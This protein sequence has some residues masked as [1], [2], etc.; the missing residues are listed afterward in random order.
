MKNVLLSILS[1]SLMNAVNS[2]AA[3]ETVF[4]DLAPV[5][6][7]S[8]LD[9]QGTPL[10]TAPGSVIKVDRSALKAKT[11][12]SLSSALGAEPNIQFNGGPRGN[13]QTPQIRGM[14]STRV[15]ILEDGVRQNFQNG[16][17]GRALGDYSLIES[18]E[19]VKGPWSSLYGSGAMGGV[20][21]VRRATAG[22]FI[23]RTG[24][25]TGVETALEG[26]SA[27]EEFGQRVTA[28]A[29]T[30]NF[31]PLISFHHL[32]NS[33]IKLSNGETLPY[34]SS[35]SDDFYS[36]LT[37]GFD[38]KQSFT[39]KL[40]RYRED[41]KTPLDPQTDT[42]DLTK[43]GRERITKTDFIGDYK[44]VRSHVDFHAK[45]YVRETEIRKARM[46]DGQTDTQKVKTAGIDAWNNLT[47]KV[48]DDL[49]S[50]IT[51]GFEYFKDRDSGSR[52]GGSLDSFP[53]GTSEQ[54]GL[55][56]QPT[57]AVFKKLTLVP[58]LR[59]DSFK[60]EVEGQSGNSGNKTSLKTYVTYEYQPEKTVYV[61]WSQAFNAP[62]LQDIYISG[63][64]FPGNF[65]VANPN[66]K[67]ETEDTWEAGTKNRFAFAAGDVLFLDATYF[68][69]HAR[70]FIS[71]HVDMG[72]GQ[73]MFVNL[74]RVRLHGFELSARWQREIFGLGLSYGRVRSVN[75]NTSEPLEDTSP[76]QWTAKVEVFPSDRLTL[77]TEI[78]LASEQDRVPAGVDRTPGYFVENF[79]VSYVRKPC[80]ITLRI[81]NAYNRTYRRHGSA[82]DETARDARLAVSW[83]F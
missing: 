68:E 44:L 74:D 79:Y 1:L 67:P 10:V 5:V 34:S 4:S 64:H 46:S 59:Y 70:D 33:D 72:A 14:S 83:L 6:V 56:L 55:Y 35:E 41:S 17:N 75:T 38:P 39:L 28:F 77:G 54:W 52:D 51:T 37:Y 24:R 81:N 61:G 12:E 27:A 13:S 82:I 15:L 9:K 69:T 30:G 7:T 40:D 76:D 49:K 42:N 50:V 3:E 80:E 26:A 73:T 16:H 65:F 57:V 47:L 25:N 48:S 45:P 71:R 31:E 32:K 18:L 11:P 60:N 63:E 78:I 20:F 66:L 23:Q 53:S 21:S 62:R 36:A 22:D 43:V 2:A 19:V 29:K 58:G 8:D